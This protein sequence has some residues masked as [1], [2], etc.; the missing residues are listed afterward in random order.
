MTID[1]NVGVGV[2]PYK[3]AKLDPGDEQCQLLDFILK[4]LPLMHP[5]K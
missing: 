3:R 5:E 1:D 4:I 2:A